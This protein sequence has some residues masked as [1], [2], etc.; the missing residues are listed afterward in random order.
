ML[1]N[2]LIISK[3]DENKVRRIDL[4]VDEAPSDVVYDEESIDTYAMISVL[5]KAVQELY[6]TI[7]E[8]R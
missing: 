4:I 5:W 2:I 8:G 6:N 7:K 3:E 1:G